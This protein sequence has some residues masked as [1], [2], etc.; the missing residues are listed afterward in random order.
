[1]TIKK[2]AGDKITGLASDT[3]STNV[4]E[5]ATFYELDTGKV[6]RRYSSSWTEIE[7]TKANNAYTAA[8][9]AYSQAN[10]AYTQANLVF[11]TA[12]NA[13]LAWDQANTARGGAN[14]VGGY[15]NSAYG[16]AN[17]AWSQA[18][19]AFTQA[20]L[21]FGTANTGPAAF[22]QANTARTGANT[23]G[24]YAN[25]AFAQA[26]LAWSQ[27]NS[28]FT[29]ANLVFGTAN[30]G[31]AAFDQANT[32]RTGANTANITADRAWNHANAAFDKANVALSNTAGSTFNGNLIISGGFTVTIANT[33]PLDLPGEVAEFV[34]NANTYAQIHARN[35]NTQQ[36]ASVDIVAT[37]DTGTDILDFIDL[38]I[39]N[40]GY[41]QPTW[42]L[43][44]A[45]DGYL[46]TSH[47]NLTV[48]VANV[49]RS[50]TFFTGGTLA[51]NERMRIDP[52]GNVLYGRT[53]STVGQGVKLDI[54]G[55]VNASAF[56]VNGTALTT[57]GAAA[58]V[59]GIDTR[60]TTSYIFFKDSTSGPLSNA[61]VS[62]SL[63]YNPS[64]GTLSSTLFNSTSDESFKYDVKII[65]DALGYIDGMNGV[66]FKWK[67]N[68]EP[69][70]GVI[71]QDIEKI[72]PELVKNDGDYKTVNYNGIIAVLI[73]AIKELKLEVEDLKYKYNKIE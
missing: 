48:G 72:L 27:A 45:R 28:A 42:T 43:N 9:L 24:G 20:N 66:R 40:S 10:S 16:A 49:S 2:Y 19:S 30:T 56:L 36:G 1:M 41:S 38:G 51:V 71:A 18:N 68:D 32:A 6:Y 4:P 61:N 35:A 65:K 7:V 64:T 17:L 15:A 53:D 44:G 21:V 46:Y 59:I 26:N 39:N 33:T 50:I 60:N 57:G 23:V 34:N 8:N 54:A 12:N 29:Q 73:E 3:K 22:D 55:A 31:P 5:G 25:S 67:N 14:T 37:A 47:G 69:S 58:A 70:L 62:T 13:G 11:G 52:S 63:T